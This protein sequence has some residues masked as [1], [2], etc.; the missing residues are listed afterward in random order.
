[1]ADHRWWTL[2]ELEATDERVAPP[3]LAALVRS[4]L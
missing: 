1:M 3:G 2:E 4:S